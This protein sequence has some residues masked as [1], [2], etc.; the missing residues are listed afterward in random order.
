M[1]T[2]PCGD[3]SPHPTHTYPRPPWP[4]GRCGGQRKEHTHMDRIHAD[5][6][7]ARIRRTLTGED[8]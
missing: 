7:A 8:T 2:P 5:C 4:P 6:L 3:P 1:T